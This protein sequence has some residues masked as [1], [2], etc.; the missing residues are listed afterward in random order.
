[1]HDRRF[2]GLADTLPASI[3]LGSPAEGVL[4]VSIARAEER[5]ALSD[6]TVLGLAAEV[7]PATGYLTEALI[8]SIAQGDEEA[9][10]RIRDF[11]A[12]RAPKVVALK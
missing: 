7:D 2:A 6:I 5:N 3:R 1:M 9:R 4:L 12:E 11:L 10:R 8:A